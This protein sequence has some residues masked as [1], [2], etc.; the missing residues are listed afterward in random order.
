MLA[1][2]MATGVQMG[3]AFIVPRFA[4]EEKAVPDIDAAGDGQAI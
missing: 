3:K 2:A 1:R 4:G